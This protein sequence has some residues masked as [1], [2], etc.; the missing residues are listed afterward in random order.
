[1]TAVE[2]KQQSVGEEDR[3]E[4]K[5]NLS[6]SNIWFHLVLS[7]SLKN[8]SVETREKKLSWKEEE[9]K[10]EKNQSRLHW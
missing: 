3:N 9:K 5:R 4:T 6:S 8:F 7:N 2:G 1:M 10:E